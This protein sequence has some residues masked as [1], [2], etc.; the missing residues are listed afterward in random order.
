MRNEPT[1]FSKL[2]KAMSVA[3]ALA[4]VA[5][6]GGSSSSKPAY[7]TDRSNLDSSVQGLKSAATSRDVDGLKSSATKVQS[8]A[9][10]LVTSAKSDFP[11]ETSAVKSSVDTLE[12][13]VN[14]LP[15]S[16]SPQQ[17]VPIVTGAASVVTSVQSFSD[18]SKS[19]CS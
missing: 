9:T 19:K 16:P 13:A 15:T 7:C 8:D 10:S 4:V 1:V 14:A 11:T 2:L 5:G 18:A 3:V 6:C 12:S 17:I